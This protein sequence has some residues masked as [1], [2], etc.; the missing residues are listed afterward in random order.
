[1]V[2]TFWKTVQALLRLAE[3]RKL[4]PLTEN[5]ARLHRNACFTAKRVREGEGGEKGSRPGKRV[6]SHALPAGG[7]EGC[8]LEGRST[9]VSFDSNFATGYLAEREIGV[10]VSLTGPA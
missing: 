4:S 8:F 10:S 6:Q 5:V 2:G 7:A 3:S 1:V 9:C